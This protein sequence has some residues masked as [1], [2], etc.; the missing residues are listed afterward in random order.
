MADTLHKDL[1][2]SEVHEPKHISSA[3]TSDSGKVITPSSS[4]SGISVLRKLSP[5]D[6]DYTDKAK[7]IFG[8]NDISDSLY[9]SGSPFALT[10]GVRTQLTN[11]GAAVQSDTT[12]LGAI[13]DNS[14]NQ[15]VINDLGGLY[16]L[17]I[18]F[19]VTAAAAA[20]T[21]YQITTELE[22][23]SGPTIISTENRFVKGGGVVNGFSISIPFYVGSV[24]SNQPLKIY[25]QSDTNMNLYD[26]GFLVHRN[27][28]E[29]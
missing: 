21:P 27:Y 9:T 15:F 20:S 6:L 28:T 24:V 3:T 14:L 13:W 19:K 26:I 18:N 17:R 2:S 7:N 11:N 25:L 5:Q 22:S 10:S 29:Q 8:W 23:S 4:T 12:R 16:L 1:Q